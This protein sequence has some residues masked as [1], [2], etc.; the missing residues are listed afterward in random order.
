M[1]SSGKKI[2]PDSIRVPGNEATLAGLLDDSPLGMVLLSSDYRILYSNRICRDLFSSRIQGSSPVLLTDLVCPE[3]RERMH[4]ALTLHALAEFRPRHNEIRF[5]RDDGTERWM[6]VHMSSVHCVGPDF[7]AK[8]V[9]QLTD[10]DQRKRDAMEH[11]A[12]EERWNS[13]LVSSDLGVWDHDFKTGTMYYSDTWK[14]LRGMAANEEVDSVTEDW[15][16]KVHPDDRAHVQECIRRQ[17]AGEVAFSI[18]EYRELHKKG[19]WIWIECRGSCVEWDENGKPTRIVGTDIDISARKSTE[20]EL[21]RVSHRLEL[22][23]TVTRIGVFEADISEGSLLLDDRLLS[24]MDLEGAPRC[25]GPDDWKYIIH[26]EDREM[27]RQRIDSSV[28]E[29]ADF[30]NQFRI[31]RKDGSIR[32]IRARVA[33]FEDSSGHTKYIGANWDVTEDIEVRQELERAKL[34]AEARN[35]ELE[36]AKAKIEHNAL[37]DFLTDLPNRRYLDDRL[38][39]RDPATIH[40]LA[41][42]HIDLDRFKQ[43][44]DTLG[45]QAGDSMLMHAAKVLREN[46]GPDEFVAR[47]GG[48]EFVVLSPFDGAKDKLTRLADKIIRRMCEPVHFNGMTCRI[49]AS[50]G[51]A[52]DPHPAADAKQL[53]LN[54]D[55]ALY[56]AKSRGRNRHE[57]FTLDIQHQVINN[58]LVSDEILVALEK[59]EFVPFYQLQFS[60]QTLDIAGAETLARWAHPTKGILGPDSFLTIAEDLDVVAAIDSVILQKALVDLEALRRHGIDI[61]NLSVNVSTR[62][63]YDPK[64]A[65]KLDSLDIQP[66][67]VS[68]EL[69]ESIFLDDCD[70]MVRDNLD[71]IRRKGIGI[72]IDDFGSGHASIVS[73]L[74]IGPGTL[75]IDRELIFPIDKTAEQRRLVRSIID[76]G[77]SLGIRVVAEGVETREHIRILQDLGCDVLQGY[78]LARPMQFSSLESFIHQQKWRAES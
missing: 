17:N 25:Q 29:N 9:V 10:I 67:R 65:E 37:H 2:Q 47:I 5:I 4:F 42:L 57:F 18:F 22:A 46:T 3:D 21:A 73:L 72:E 68:F 77:K 31:V 56:R 7:V 20:E 33:P 6:S 30:S 63:L 41:V 15:L 55:I 69:L 66:G 12:W 52:C 64:L 16:Q 44:N 36:D 39:H 27:T 48:D 24:I 13:A 38:G 8:I 26:P 11:R 78:A 54:A 70:E 43:I 28:S 23:L 58:K 62:R 50:I 14:R 75:K 1:A 40:G 51:I 32:H 76:I 59:D 34:L 60:A 35:R 53:L 49:G 45:H 71:A 61:P 19:H 74:K